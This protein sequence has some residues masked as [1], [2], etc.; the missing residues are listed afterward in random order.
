[1]IVGREMSGCDGIY[2][3]EIVEDMLRRWATEVDHIV[4]ENVLVSANRG[5]WLRLA[6]ELE[7]VNHAVWAHLDTPFEVCMERIYE[8][9]ARRAAEGWK[10]RQKDGKVD[11]EIIYTHWKRCRR[12]ATRA[13]VEDGMDVRWIDHQHAY[14]QAHDMLVR[15]GWKCGHGLLR[16]DLEEPQPWI[17]TEA[18]AAAVI[19]GPGLL[20]WEEG[21]V[22]DPVP[23]RKKRAARAVVTTSE[24]SSTSTIPEWNPLNEI[25]DPFDD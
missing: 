8:R 22:I 24:V 5:R 11:D 20:P 25:G 1:V 18:E 4:W 12:T 16:P 6:Q 17:P 9:R 19:K 2:P 21:F 10:H 15:A 3:H 23:V 7:P 14:E 13:V